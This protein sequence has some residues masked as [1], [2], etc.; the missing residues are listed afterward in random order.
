MDSAE[1]LPE[2]RI[3][4]ASGSVT[5]GL[6]N[7]DCPIWSSFSLSHACASLKQLRVCSQHQPKKLTTLGRIAGE[8]SEGGAAARGSNRWRTLQQST[9]G[10]WPTYS[11]QSSTPLKGIQTT[12]PRHPLKWHPSPLQIMVIPADV[13]VLRQAPERMNLCCKVFV[14]ATATL[15]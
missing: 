15:K 8:D 2:A 13:R 1:D 3:H 11:D 14:L 7:S 9:A 4:P 5:V 10:G 6:T 12:G